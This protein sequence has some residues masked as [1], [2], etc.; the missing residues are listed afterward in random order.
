MPVGDGEAHVLKDRFQG[1]LDF[2][3]RGGGLFVDFQMNAG[4]AQGLRL[5]FA[6]G[7]D[8]GQPTGLVAHGV[9]HRMHIE[10]DPDVAAVELHGQRI[11]EERHIV[12]D[13]FHN[14]MR[15]APGILL[16]GW[17]LPAWIENANFYY[18]GTPGRDQIKKRKRGGAKILGCGCTDIVHGDMGIIGPDEAFRR[19]RL[20]APDGLADMMDNLA[21]QIRLQ[22]HWAFPPPPMGCH[23]CR[24]GPS[25]CIYGILS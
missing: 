20:A 10:M 14:R 3:K 13:D 24:H 21:D 16:P 4:F 12:V 5:G 25:R 19:S 11:H 1:L 15:T 7:G 2:L 17:F 23:G 22:S 9:H 8:I 6:V 18:P